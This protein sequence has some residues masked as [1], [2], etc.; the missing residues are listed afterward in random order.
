VEISFKNGI[1]YLAG[2]IDEHADFGSLTRAA[3]P[4]R[5]NLGKIKSINSV[6]V[7][8]MLAF[9]LAWSPKP[10]EFHECTA[11]FIVNVN[12]IPQ[13]LG[14]SRDG[15]QIKSFYVPYSC[16]ACKRLENVLY[17]PEDLVFVENAGVTLTE[18][19]CDGCGEVLDLDVDQHDYF[20]F[21]SRS[22]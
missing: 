8:K 18:K 2:R 7:R 22:V 6:G 9:A 19:F 14:S 15:Q 3:E 10:F 17:R 12:V 20:L 21:L 5:L 11:E 13:L 1:H 4:L 16:E